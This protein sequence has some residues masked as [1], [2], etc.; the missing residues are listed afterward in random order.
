MTGSAA[1]SK[2]LLAKVPQ[3][4]ALFWLIKILTTGIGEAM[5][6]FLAAQD[7]PIAATVALLGFLAAFGWQLR[8]RRYFAPPYWLTVAMVAVV[9]T[10]VADVVHLIGVP[11]LWSSVICLVTVAVLFSLWYAREG[12][13]SIHSVDRR[14]RELFYWATVSATFAL[15]TAVGDLAAISFGWGY[16]ISVLVFAG[17]IVIPLIGWR[18]F[19][20]NAVFAFWAAYVL[21]RPLGASFADWLAKPASRGGLGFGDGPVALAGLIAIAIGVAYLTARS[22][23]ANNLGSSEPLPLPEV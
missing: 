21:T 5:S 13:L 10:M 8:T 9:G 4:T 15:G 1:D 2:T 16:L 3:I 11:Y 22:A 7:I 12:T 19:G 6:D 17:L 18:W 20:L 14:S 23:R